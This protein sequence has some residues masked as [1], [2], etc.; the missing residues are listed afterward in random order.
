MPTVHLDYLM[1]KE[2][3][4]FIIIRIAKFLV[5]ICMKII[6]LQLE[7]EIDIHRLI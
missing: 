3:T 6:S 7:S 4:I 2:N 5:V 1:G